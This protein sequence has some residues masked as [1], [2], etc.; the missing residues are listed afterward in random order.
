MTDR[1]AGGARPGQECRRRGEES[2]R[3]ERA[4]VHACRHALR[5]QSSASSL[6]SPASRWRPSPG[7]AAGHGQRLVRDRGGRGLGGRAHLH[8]VRRRSGRCGHQL[9]R[10]VPGH[11]RRRLL[12]HRRG[13]DVLHAHP[14]PYVTTVT[15]Y[16][17][18]FG[19]GGTA[20][21]ACLAY[22]SLSNTVPGTWTTAGST[23]QVMKPG[24]C[25]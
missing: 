20:L 17:Y 21:T 25:P 4:A 7:D 22:T 12:H 15:E 11:R 18:A 16:Y 3:V 24:A 13:G 10:G 2:A 23:K 19:E 8:A 6:L 5:P 14:Y 9:R 1:R